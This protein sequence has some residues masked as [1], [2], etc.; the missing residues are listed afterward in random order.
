V[1]HVGEEP[2]QA[3]D[4]LHAEFGRVVEGRP[5]E[6]LPAEIRLCPD[7]DQEVV[8]TAGRLRNVELVLGPGDA[9]LKVVHH[10]DLGTGVGEDKELFGFDLGAGLGAPLADQVAERARRDL[11][12]VIPAREGGEEDRVAELGTVQ[13]KEMVHAATPRLRRSSSSEYSL[14]ILLLTNQTDVL[15]NRDGR[16]DVRP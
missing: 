3:H 10:A 16:T 5:D 12:R 11:R 6:G 9:A 14:A 4:H 2:T 8:G 1:Q 15:Y 7:E 13:L